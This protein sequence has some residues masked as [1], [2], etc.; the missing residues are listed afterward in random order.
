MNFKDLEELG[1]V[2]VYV[3][4]IESGNKEYFYYVY[5]F[6]ENP[7]DLYL[8]SNDSDEKRCFVEIFNENEII[9]YKLSEVKQLI[10]I[11][12]KGIKQKN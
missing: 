9:Y 8:I 4:E 1:F 10:K 3:Q 7:R 11:I 5:E 12:K 6:F 2:K